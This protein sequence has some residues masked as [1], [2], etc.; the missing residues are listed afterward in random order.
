[1]FNTN[2]IVLERQEPL[3]ASYRRRPAEAMIVKRATAVSAAGTDALHGIV[4]PGDTYGLAWPVGV[5]R[6]IGGLHD[7]PNPAELLCAAL[8]ACKDIS[9]RMV[10][11][12][13]GIALERLEVKVVGKVDV[14]G[15]MAM[16]RD[17]SVGFQSLACNVRLAVAQGTDPERLAALLAQAERSCINLATLRAGVPVELAFDV[18]G[19]DVA[20]LEA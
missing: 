16:D 15:C 7:A 10:A 9:I 2:S 14:R 1:M 8:A 13:L 17:T 18:Q 6:A 5:D 11:D 4:S 3:R 12:V 19:S 20:R